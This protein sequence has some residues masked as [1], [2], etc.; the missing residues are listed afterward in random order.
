MTYTAPTR[1]GERGSRCQWTNPNAKRVLTS[2]WASPAIN[3][4]FLHHETLLVEH[5]LC[6]KVHFFFFKILIQLGKK[7]KLNTEN[8]DTLGYR[9]V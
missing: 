9:R 3:V 2:W 1:P 4:Q 5:P 6:S 7:R 8:I